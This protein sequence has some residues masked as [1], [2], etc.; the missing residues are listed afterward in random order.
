MEC[1]DEFKIGQS[2]VFVIAEIGINHNG[3]MDIAKD[4]ILAAK[5][6]DADAVKFQKRSI[7]IVYSPSLL[8]SYR[9]SP[10]G[11]TQREQKEGLEFDQEDYLEIDDFCKDV[12]I[13]WFASAWDIES[14][15]FLRQFNLKYN[16]VASA[17]TTNLEFLD[18][19]AKENLPTFISTGMCTIDEISVAV[20]IFKERKCPLVLMHTCSEYPAINENL[21]LKMILTLKDKFNINVGYSGHETSVIPS[22]FAVAL[23]AVAVERHLT[24]DRA[25]YG[26]D[27]SASLEPRGF[28]SMVEKIREFNDVYGD[29]VKKITE[30]EHEIAEKLRY[31]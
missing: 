19:V 31:W 7:D 21:N 10:W 30:K 29:G 6:N 24:L 2:R 4:L 8:D 9:E 20:D 26:S 15:K 5:N 22:V 28:K 25:M 13:D 23:G 17:M 27:Q 16:K 3:N 14:Q 11:T 18:T 12:G 1:F